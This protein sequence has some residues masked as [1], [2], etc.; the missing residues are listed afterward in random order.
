MTEPL[1]RRRFGALA[2]AVTLLAATAQRAHAASARVV[3]VGGGFAGATFARYL[4]NA[5]PDVDITLVDPAV[6]YYTCPF[7][8][9]VVAGQ[10]PLEFLAV[11]RRRN[12][13]GKQVRFLARAAEGIDPA[14]K[15]V[16]LAGGETLEADLLVVAPGVS[17]VTDTID[18]WG[19]EAAEAM[20]H[21]WKAGRQTRRL[22]E[23]LRAMPDGGRVLIAVPPMPYRCPPGPYERASLMA[24][25]LTRH[26]P[27]AKIRVIDASGGMPKGELFRQGWEALYPRMIERI[28]VAAPNGVDAVDPTTMTLHAG[29]RRFAGDVVNLIP[30]HCA[31]A[32]AAAADLTDASGWCPVRP[33]SFE[34]TRHDDV[35]V[36]GDAAASPLPKSAAAGNSAAKV[37]AHAIAARLTGRDFGPPSFINACYSFLEP[38]YAIGIGMV[39]DVRDG[40]IH[41]I[42]EGSGTSPLNASREYRREEAEDA[43]GWYRSVVED[44]FCVSA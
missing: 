11:D 18:G 43:R 1:S 4:A 13:D 26:N 34:S 23:Q 40:R 22:H 21:A 24:F 37:C 25:Y 44:S 14:A 38:G 2:G 8:N 42:E 12:R 16:R 19:P 32:I 35:F 20:P 3:V 27:K 39:Y 17:F 15:T 31:G 30:L 28:E 7:S 33:E 41:Q 6:P 10:Q 29:D 5:A 9:F 36:I